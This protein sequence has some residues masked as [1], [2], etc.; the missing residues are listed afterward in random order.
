V[1]T[2]E[3]PQ[4][5][6]ENLALGRWVAARV[7]NLN[8]ASF[9][10]VAFFEAGVG[11]KAV[12]MFHNYRQTDIEIVIASE[13]R[14]VQRDLINMVLRYPFTIG[15]QRI[16]AIIR[17]DNRKARKLVQQLGFRQEGKLRNADFDGEDMFIYGLL[18]GENRLERDY[19]QKVS[20]H[21]AAAA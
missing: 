8:P 7:P 9:L 12:V 5:D 17:K 16:T 11:I 6:P 14:W 13:G 1:I 10:C 19:G 4:S 3:F 15:C 21:T 2:L 20:T 18:S